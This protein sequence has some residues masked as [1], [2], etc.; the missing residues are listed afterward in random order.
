MTK[1][2]THGMPTGAG[3]KGGRAPRKKGCA[4][5]PTDENRVP[6]QCNQALV[7]SGSGNSGTQIVTTA[8]RADADTRALLSDA[9][10]L[11]PGFFGINNTTP[12]G[13]GFHTLTPAPPYPPIVGAAYPYSPWSCSPLS[14][15]MPPFY[16]P[17]SSLPPAYNM[18]YP[19]TSGCPSVFTLCFKTGNISVCSGCRRNFTQLDDLVVRHAEHRAFN[20]PRTGL[21]TSK[22]GN[23]YYHPKQLCLGMKWGDSFQSHKLV[24]DDSMRPLLSVFHKEMILKEFGISL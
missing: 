4:L 16:G 11:V 21:P 1:M 7:V 9:T 3:R 17:Q 5:L 10:P 14:S 22:Y 19:G 15:S 2:A 12:C 18:K 20:S 6:L 8:S 13:S 23:A 24:I